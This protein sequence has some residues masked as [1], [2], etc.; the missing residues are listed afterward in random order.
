MLPSLGGIAANSMTLFRLCMESLIGRNK[1]ISYGANM[2]TRVEPKRGNIGELD[3]LPYM[4]P[5]GISGLYA[6]SDSGHL[7]HLTTRYE[8]KF[9][10]S[11]FVRQCAARIRIVEEKKNNAAVYTMSVP[12]KT[13]D[14]THFVYIQAVTVAEDEHVAVVGDIHGGL[15]NLR[16][17]IMRLKASGWFKDDEGSGFSLKEGKRIVSLGDLVDRGPRSREVVH[18]ILSLKLQKGNFNKVHIVNGNHEDD[19][20]YRTKC[21]SCLPAAVFMRF[22][23]RGKW[24]QFCHGGIEESLIG[25]IRTR[26]RFVSEDLNNEWLKVPCHELCGL[27]WSDFHVLEKQDGHSSEARCS[28]I[29]PGRGSDSI[30]SYSQACTDEY[31]K[32]INAACII[33]GHQDFAHGYMV[34][35][36]ATEN[37]K[38]DVLVRA[39]LF[40]SFDANHWMKQA[41]ELDRDERCTLTFGP[42]SSATE[43][44]IQ[45]WSDIGN[46]TN[47]MGPGDA[48]GRIRRI[49]NQHDRQFQ[50]YAPGKR[51]DWISELIQDEKENGV[52]NKITNKTISVF[53]TTAASTGRRLFIEQL[54]VVQKASD[55]LKTN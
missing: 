26:L 36:R 4:D 20:E 7:E 11:E 17:V 12:L 41:D 40:K 44:P 37:K 32:D 25:S 45:S 38:P 13:T 34:L 15:C 31:L 19:S 3:A 50:L 24:I 28:K 27:K 8:M 49:I 29:A 54:L 21:F 16:N 18:L 48:N 9:V 46:C 52:M 14:D 30:R 47:D 39:Y 33:R 53:T 2:S 6:T 1:N 5:N 51:C 23:P 10:E 55:D 42:L 43:Y 35:P 22:G